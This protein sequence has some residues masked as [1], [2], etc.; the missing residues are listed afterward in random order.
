[1]SAIAETL[2]QTAPAWVTAEMPPGYQNRLAEIE[3]LVADLE[4][5]G[6]FGRLLWQVGGPLAETACD[7]FKTLKF[8]SHV[9]ER[10]SDSTVVVA[11]DGA[12]RL[13]LLV[14]PTTEPVPKKG[15]ELAQVFRLLHEVAGDADRVVLVLNTEPET[16]P[17]DRAP[18]MTAEAATFLR[19]MGVS[20]L[21]GATI[22]GLWKMSLQDP[23]RARTHVERLF[24]QDGG[25]FELSPSFLK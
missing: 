1:M 22:F 12:R 5:M 6:R 8:E 7:A 20:Y 2:A 4:A 16:P 25:L 11:L 9:A 10:S 19:R 3:R 15:A 24:A 14:S 21:S 23:S 13:L 17:A 18:A